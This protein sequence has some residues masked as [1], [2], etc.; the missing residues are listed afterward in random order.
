MDV[1]EKLGMIM[2]M[3]MGMDIARGRPGRT[4]IA[5]GQGDRAP[6]RAGDE[7]PCPRELRRRAG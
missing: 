2:W 1:Q 6:G 7:V 3:N 5:D 4:G